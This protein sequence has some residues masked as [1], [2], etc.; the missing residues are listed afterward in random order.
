MRPFLISAVVSGLSMIG[1]WIYFN[2]SIDN[3]YTTFP[4]RYINRS[5]HWIWNEIANWGY[6]PHWSLMLT[7]VPGL[8]FSIALYYRL[9]SRVGEKHIILFCI[10]SLLGISF[11]FQAARA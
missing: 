11:S 6:L 9:K 1:L 2:Y 5:R 8:S 3:Y 4:W 7:L 10:T